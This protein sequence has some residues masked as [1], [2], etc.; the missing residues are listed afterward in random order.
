MRKYNRLLLGLAAICF[1]LVGVLSFW[2]LIRPSDEAVSDGA[3]K[4]TGANAQ[5]SGTPRAI[6]PPATAAS[7][8]A[9][10]LAQT[11]KQTVA[12]LKSSRAQVIESEQSYRREGCPKVDDEEKRLQP[13]QT[14]TVSRRITT[15]DGCKNYL[16]GFDAY[17]TNLEKFVKET[18]KLDQLQS[19]IDNLSAATRTSP[20]VADSTD[21]LSWTSL[22]WVVVASIITS[23]VIFLF[24]T[25]KRL[26]NQGDIVAVLS[27]G[28]LT[29]RQSLEQLQ[30][31]LSASGQLEVAGQGAQEHSGQRATPDQGAKQATQLSDALS[32][33]V[34]HGFSNVQESL[35]LILSKLD[36]NLFRPA[37]QSDQQRGAAAVGPEPPR[38]S[39]PVDD[40]SSP[41]SASPPPMTV[42]RYKTTF[43]V[44]DCVT[45]GYKTGY[46]EKGDGGELSVFKDER[47]KKYYLIPNSE[48]LQTPSYFH[49]KYA[50][51]YDALHLQVGSIE[52]TSPAIVRPEGS[53]WCLERKGTLTIKRLA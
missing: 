39:A 43:G 26:F 30:S 25:G 31:T 35:K 24:I 2:Y 42:S 10:K 37:N 48:W 3:P 6:Q 38:P 34:R 51:Y 11:L 7:D 5:G 44:V 19:Q 28:F 33:D 16:A 14:L 45:P 20:P 17:H 4:Q 1:V 32:K 29:I 21:S 40:A 13:G 22:L 18:G 53:Q 41:S 47:A 8:D 23:L 46:L 36:K 15:A 9:G 49:Q 12:E 27:H 50:A 52:V